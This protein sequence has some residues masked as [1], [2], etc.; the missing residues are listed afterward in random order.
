LSWG[1]IVVAAGRGTRFGRPKQL[2]ELAGRPMLAWSLGVFAAMPEVERIVV[3]TEEEW[4]DRVEA[5]A[6]EVAGTKL[7]ATVRGGAT[8]QQSV[9]AGLRAMDERCDAVFV[10]DGAR[11]LVRATD[12]RAGMARTHAGQGAVLAAPVVDTIKVV[13]PDTMLVERTLDRARLWG[14]QT[15]QFAT[16][17][18][19]ERAHAHAAANGL[20]LTDDVALLEAVGVSV[21]IVAASGDNFKVTHPNDV[22][23]AEGLLR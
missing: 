20:D 11:P 10:H 8:R 14:A 7:H 6:R 22:V 17:A 2:I 4:R 9:A 12:V 18:D 23:R 5:L 3:V 15:P 19:L 13:D 16:R 21:A 1:A